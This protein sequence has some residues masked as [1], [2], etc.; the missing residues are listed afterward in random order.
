[1]LNVMKK[2]QKWR[3]DDDDDDNYKDDDSNDE[4]EDIGNAN[5]RSY[6]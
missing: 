6:N 2:L 3:I 1:M 5:E 4:G